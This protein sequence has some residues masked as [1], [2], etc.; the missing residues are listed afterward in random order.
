MS[1]LNSEHLD[2]ALVEHTGKGTGCR[3]HCGFRP[4]GGEATACITHA[5]FREQLPG[6]HPLRNSERPLIWV[7]KPA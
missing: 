4:E 2:Y 6:D 5:C 1:Y 3:T 7:R